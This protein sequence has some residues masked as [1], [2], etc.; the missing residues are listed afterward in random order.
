MI[1]KKAKN[2][3]DIN[4]APQKPSIFEIRKN[5]MDE[6][7]MSPIYG[8]SFSRLMYGAS[9]IPNMKLGTLNRTNCIFPQIV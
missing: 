4:V 9:H 1:K 8:T 2:G 7:I 5:N 6:I 3:M